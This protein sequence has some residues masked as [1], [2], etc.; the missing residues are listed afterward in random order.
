MSSWSSELGCGDQIDNRNW[1]ATTTRNTKL[2]I[3]KTTKY[4]NKIKYNKPDWEYNKSD[5][6]Y[7][8]F[9]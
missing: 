1:L 9:N 5:C 3:N 8:K 6:K 2:D 4:G 7:N